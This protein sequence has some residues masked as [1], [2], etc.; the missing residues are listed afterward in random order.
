MVAIKGIDMPKECYRCPI[1][2]G[3]YGV[4]QIIGEPKVDMTE[5]RAKNCPLVEIIT[6]KDCRYNYEN[7]CDMY[8][9][10]VIDEYFCAG[11]ERREKE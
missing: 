4:C 7:N 10:K 11:A 6:C 8:G 9:C 3:E 2:D 5:E 1:M